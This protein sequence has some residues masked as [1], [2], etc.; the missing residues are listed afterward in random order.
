[1]PQEHQ[2][3]A[4][5]P[6]SPPP[7]KVLQMEPMFFFSLSLTNFIHK[8]TMYDLVLQCVIMTAAQQQLHTNEHGALVCVQMLKA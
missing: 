1:M 4:T 5:Y 3:S 2:P 6:S 7:N 8:K